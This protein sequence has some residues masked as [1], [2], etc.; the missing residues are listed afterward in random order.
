[1]LTESSAPAEWCAT[2]D[3]ANKTDPSWFA[4]SCWGNLQP[5]HDLQKNAGNTTR[6][7]R[8]TAY[9]SVSMLVVV[10]EEF[11]QVFSCRY[12]C[13][14]WQFGQHLQIHINPMVLSLIFSFRLLPRHS[15]AKCGTTWLVGPTLK[16][17]A[18]TCTYMTTS[19]QLDIW[20]TTDASDG[21]EISSTLPR[22]GCP[23]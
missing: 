21:G 19:H 14:R 15:C 11:L 3:A 9:Q 23:T 4:S 13:H 10:V 6:S 12:C 1:M 22:I 18:P 5:G 17:T 7:E 16:L 20:E 8:H 2:F